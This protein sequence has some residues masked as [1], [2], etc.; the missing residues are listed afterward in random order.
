MRSST[1]YP[2]FAL[3]SDMCRMLKLSTNPVSF[4]KP[5]RTCRK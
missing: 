1:P 4:N 3:I 2:V 5:C